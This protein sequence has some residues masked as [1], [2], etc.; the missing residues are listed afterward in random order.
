M[1]PMQRSWYPSLSASR[2][3]LP[4]AIT[5]VCVFLIQHGASAVFV[6][7]GNESNQPHQPISSTAP[8]PPIPWAVRGMRR[9]G[10]VTTADDVP[11]DDP[12][13]FGGPLT[14]N[15]VTPVLLRP[16]G[17]KGYFGSFVP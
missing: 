16:F 5:V 14:L 17:A 13:I 11:L 6:N 3:L 12:I 2:W 7:A 4:V 15:E 9:I 10:S 8:T 1:V